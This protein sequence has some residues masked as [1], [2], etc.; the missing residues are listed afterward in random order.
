MNADRKQHN[1]DLTPAK[2]HAPS[3]RIRLT[4]WADTSMQILPI[5]PGTTRL[6]DLHADEVEENPQRMTRAEDLLRVTTCDMSYTAD[7]IPDEPPN[8]DDLMVPPSEFKNLNRVLETLALESRSPLDKLAAIRAFFIDHKF[9]YSL[10]AG[11]QRTRRDGYT[12]LGR[13]L[14]QRQSGHCEYYATATALLLRQ[15]GIPSRYCTGYAVQEW[16]ADREEYVLRRRHRHAWVTAWVDGRWLHVDT[17]PSNGDM[18][19]ESSRWLTGIRDAFSRFGMFFTKWRQSEVGSRW[20]TRIIRAAM[21]A[22]I[23]YAIWRMLRD[24]G[25][26]MVRTDKKK[27]RPSPPG[28]DSEF[29]E[30]EAFLLKQGAARRSSHQP[31]AEWIEDIA[32]RLNPRLQSELRLCSRLHHRYRF[33]PQ[34]LTDSQRKELRHRCRELLFQFQTAR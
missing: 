33:D 13:F 11:N 7:L 17:T 34:G 25:S 14:H 28:A 24:K 6:H 22:V 2:N 4:G 1:W 9:T 16:D 19:P 27:E 12:P 18:G 3:A 20:F 31:L 26:G 5:P 21:L 8:E 30:I 23:G 15:V 10:N 32:A 29:Y